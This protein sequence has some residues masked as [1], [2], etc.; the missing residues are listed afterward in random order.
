MANVPS[1]TS[2]GKR[3]DFIDKDVMEL[4]GAGD[5]VSR[6]I[7]AKHGDIEIAILFNLAT[8]FHGRRETSDW[9]D[10]C[11]LH[12][13]DWLRRRGSVHSH[14]KVTRW[15]NSHVECTSTLKL[16]PSLTE[17]QRCAE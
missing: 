9:L 12:V 17:F 11:G 14:A 15:Q 1:L 16:H 5:K 6:A 4:S 13:A 2:A 8:M 10:R 3:T 7:F